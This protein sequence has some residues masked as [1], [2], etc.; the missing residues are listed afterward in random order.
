MKAAK[1][2]IG[3]RSPEPG[4]RSPEERGRRKNEG[5]RTSVFTKMRCSPFFC[6][7]IQNLK[8]KI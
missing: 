2:E 8:S 1:L 7:R 6:L 4:A 3:V 5:A